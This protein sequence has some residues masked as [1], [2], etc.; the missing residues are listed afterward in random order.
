MAVVSPITAATTAALPVIVDVA[1]GGELTAV[2]GAGVLLALVA[3]AAIAG[4]RSAQ[5]L[6]PR[7]LAMA[8]AAGVGFAVFFIFISQTDEASG[9]WPLSHYL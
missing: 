6:N 4:E 9:F 1:T 2:A 7:L 8:L 5:R 3:I